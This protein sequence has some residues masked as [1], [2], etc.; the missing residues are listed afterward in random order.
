MKKKNPN[1]L[2]LFQ[3]P[4]SLES[5]EVFTP[6]DESKSVFL[7]DPPIELKASVL[8]QI[9]RDMEAL[10][11]EFCYPD[12]LFYEERIANYQAWAKELA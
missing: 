2:D 7:L 8:W 4:T 6:R 12:R 1:Q 11:D 9:R 3:E 5:K 10:E